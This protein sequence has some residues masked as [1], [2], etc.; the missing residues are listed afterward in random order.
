M[1]L[2]LYIGRRF[3]FLVPQVFSDLVHHLRSS[4]PAAGRPRAPLAGPPRARILGRDAARQDVSGPADP[5]AICDLAGERLSGRSRRVLGQQH[6]GDRRSGP[7]HSG[8]AGAHLPLAVRRLPGAGSA[9]HHHREPHP[10]LDR[11]DVPEHHLRLRHVG[12]RAAGLPARPG[13]D[14]LP[15]RGRSGADAIGDSAWA[16]RAAR[17]PRLRSALRDRLDPDRLA[18]RGRLRDFLVGLHAPDHAGLHPLLRLRRAHLQDA[19]E[20]DG[21]RAQGRLHN[22]C[23]GRGARAHDR[24]HTRRQGRRRPR[25]WSSPASW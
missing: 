25:R 1:R 21:R 13:A 23:G 4:A 20:P 5:R 17:H 15:L 16:G 12:R 19:A 11:S 24:A 14:L 7:T 6:A 2:A 9:R 10:E 22:L 3:L 18:D 8:D